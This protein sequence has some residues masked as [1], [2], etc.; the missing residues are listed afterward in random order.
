M[1]GGLFL[2]KLDDD[3]PDGRHRFVTLDGMRG[4]AA[5]AVLCFHAGGGLEQHAYS[6]VDFFFMLSGF[7]LV[8]AYGAKLKDAK[9]GAR[10]MVLRLVRLYP[11]YFVGGLLGLLVAWF[12]PAEPFRGWNDAVWMSAI[13]HGIAMLPMPGVEPGI[14]PLNQP[15]WSLFMEMAVNIVFALGLWRPRYALIAAALSFPALLWGL[16]LY[17]AGGGYNSQNWVWGFARVGFSFFAGVLLYHVWRRYLSGHVLA[18]SPVFLIVALVLAYQWDPDFVASPLRALLGYPN[19]LLTLFIMMLVHPVILMASALDSRRHMLS[20]LMA[21]FG[22]I[23]YGLYIIH[24]PIMTVTLNLMEPALR[25]NPFGPKPWAA[26]LVA[27][28]LSLAVAHVLTYHA[29]MPLRRWLLGRLPGW[30]WKLPVSRAPV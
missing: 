3:A 14:F 21:W 13:L 7:V 19:M 10:F 24:Y 11:L 16:H 29:D 15:A 30:S 22:D 25:D 9:D 12:L 23:S 8:H 18:I 2:K 28:P 26:I 17:S 20:P 27:G 5:L 6:A 1:F 4:V